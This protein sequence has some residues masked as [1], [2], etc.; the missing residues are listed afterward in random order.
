MGRRVDQI[1]EQ[2]QRPPQ[3]LVRI[4]AACVLSLL[5]W[6]FYTTKPEV[7]EENPNQYNIEYATVGVD[8]SKAKIAKVSVDIQELNASTVARALRTHDVHNHMYGYKH[9]I[10]M[11]AL[12]MESLQSAEMAL[13]ATVWNKRAYLLSI[14]IAELAKPKADRLEWLL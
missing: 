8:F 3:H 14:I 1:V 11:R 7:V 5:L 13:A 12:S 6:H 4:F 9:F 2:V 10:S